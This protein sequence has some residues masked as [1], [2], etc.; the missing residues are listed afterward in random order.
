MSKA[1]AIPKKIL[2]RSREMPVTALSH[3]LYS[4][5]ILFASY[6]SQYN[7]KYQIDLRKFGKIQ[8]KPNSDS[9]SD[10]SVLSLLL[11]L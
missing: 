6:S 4:T 11:I 1:A 9:E 5:T 7:I 10:S 3:D 2:V 8:K